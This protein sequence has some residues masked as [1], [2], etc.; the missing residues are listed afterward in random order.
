M[1]MVSRDTKAAQSTLEDATARVDPELFGRNMARLIEEAGKALAAY[2]Q[3]RE[4]DGGE[5]AATDHVADMWR[6]MGRVGERLMADPKRALDAQQ[7]LMNAYLDVWTNSVRR[8]LGED[9]APAIDQGRGDKRFQDPEWQT[10]PFFDFCRQTYLATAKWA[11]EIVQ[12]T[13]DLDEHTRRKADFYTKLITSALAPTN[14]FLTNPA[15]LRTTLETNGEN[16][17]RGMHMLA[18]DIA[19][20][21]GELRVRQT[22]PHAFE[23]GRN[24]ALTPGKVIYQNDLF[25]LIQYS[26]QTEKV[27]RTP[28]LFVPPWINKYYVLDL[29]PGKSLY[30]WCVKEGVT[31]FTISWVNPDER[32]ANKSFEDYMHEGVFAALDAVKKS[33]GEEKAH[34][35]GY[36]IGGTLLASTL[37][38]AAAKK[39]D[40]F[41]SASFLTTQIDFT[42]AGDLG[43][44]VDEE[45]LKVLEERMA[46]RGYLEGKRMSMA[47]NL[48]RSNDLIWPYVVNTYMK[49]EAPQAFDLL[50]WNS[51]STRM[52]A[53]NHAYYLRNCYWENKLARGEM[54]FGD[55]KLDMK[56][57]TVPAYALATKEDHIAPA[58]SVFKGCASFGGPVRY[59]LAGSGHI[60]GVVNP[61]ERNKYQYW[62]DGPPEGTLEDWLAKAEE[63]PGSWWPDW[64]EWIRSHG[65]ERVD[66]REPGGGKL[67]PIEDAPGSYV[68]MTE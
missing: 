40:W 15:I 61:P 65:D 67:T 31:L 29:R 43:L 4:K 24:L 48:L 38:Y 1:A 59:V 35:V 21:A 9:S 64:L 3:P 26:P 53:A 39:L 36:C 2:I 32:L 33:T 54:T 44:F 5:A 22:D 18:E 58:L 51:D 46:Q 8:V 66:A 10:N 37:A 6:T 60:A 13:D 56:K 34:V 63:H 16:L 68:K 7:S 14:F 45:Q 30:E 50:H 23:V 20:G 25:Q 12:K 57:V 47:F 55:V 17:V 52:P 28:V 62:T 49:G 42:H 27:L 19:R 11:E 41:A